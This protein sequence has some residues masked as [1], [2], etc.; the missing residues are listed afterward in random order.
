M[1][2]VITRISEQMRERVSIVSFTRQAMK[3]DVI[4]LGAALH[5]RGQT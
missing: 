1:F 4:G 3:D 2:T 5:D